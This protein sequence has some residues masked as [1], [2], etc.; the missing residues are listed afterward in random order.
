MDTGTATHFDPTNDEITALKKIELG[1]P[2]PLA[3][4]LK[5]HLPP[6]LAQHGFLARGDAGSYVITALGRD[7][8]RRLGN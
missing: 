7:L 6:R 4:A 5:K 1:G 3:V 2:M 8:I